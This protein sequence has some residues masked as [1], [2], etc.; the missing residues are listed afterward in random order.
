[1]R[2]GRQTNGISCEWHMQRKLKA[3]LEGKELKYIDEL[4]VAGLGR[5]PDF[6][7][8]KAGH[9]INI[10]AKCNDFECLLDQM[11]DNSNYCDY[12][13]AFIPDYSLTPIWFKKRL[14]NSG[15]GLIVFNYNDETIT[16]VLEA[17]HNTFDKDL[18][19]RVLMSIEKQL[20]RRKKKVQ[21]D[22]Q[23]QLFFKTDENLRT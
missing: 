21:V 14:M 19:K 11:D 5:I 7:V 22:T 13:F 10:E 6:L 23:K 2:I 17:H 1:M 8:I 3:W 9:L 18:R 20:I 15:Y 12:S 16:E 4:R